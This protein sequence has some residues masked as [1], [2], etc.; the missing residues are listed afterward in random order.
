M[1]NYRPARGI[2]AFVAGILA[3]VLSPFGMIVVLAALWAA[4]L[5][6]AFIGA[7]V[8][9]IVA[10]MCRSAWSGGCWAAFCLVG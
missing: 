9:W 7:A 8:L 5:Y 10:G 1:L 3:T 4:M 6:S 2:A